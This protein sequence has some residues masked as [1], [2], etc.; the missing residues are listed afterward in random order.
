MINYIL[1]TSDNVDAPGTTRLL[2][3]D[4]G[5]VT[6]LN[7]EKQVSIFSTNVVGFKIAAYGY[8]QINV[9]MSSNDLG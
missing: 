3:E 6:I 1:E 2:A 7:Y 5:S 4:D 9:K 8:T